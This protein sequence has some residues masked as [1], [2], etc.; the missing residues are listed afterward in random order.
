[1][2]LAG[3]EFERGKFVF[4]QRIYFSETYSFLQELICTVNND[5]VFIHPPGG[6]AHFGAYTSYNCVSLSQYS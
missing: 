6:I 2:I 5:I 1:M 3:L 4:S